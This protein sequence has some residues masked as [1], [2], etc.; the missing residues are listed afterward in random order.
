M[1][2]SGHKERVDFKDLILEELSYIFGK[3][4][5]I[6]AAIDDLKQAVTDLA[7][8]VAQ[9][10]TDVTAALAI[11]KNPSS[12]DADVEAAATAIEG[13]VAILKAEAVS[14]EAALPPAPAA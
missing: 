5:Q 13:S 11:I 14:I 12:T 8:V 7:V 9:V 6:M 1:F 2:W 3:E 4:K 10:A